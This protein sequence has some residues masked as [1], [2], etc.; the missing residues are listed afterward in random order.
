MRSNS[1]RRVLTSVAAC[2]AV[3]AVISEASAAAPLLG[4]SFRTGG[5]TAGLFPRMY[6]VDLASGAA[7]NP[8]SI[9]VNNTVGIACDPSTGIL[10]GATDQ[11][12]RINNQSGQ[13]GKNLLFTI[14]RATGAAVG[15]GRFDPAGADATQLFEGDLAF[16]PGTNQLYA[17]STRVTSATLMKIDKATG[18]A[19]IVGAIPAPAGVTNFDC[20]AMAFASNGD[21]YVLDS[22]FPPETAGGKTEKAR[23]LRV[24]VTTGALLD[25]IQTPYVLGS[26]AGM[27]IDPASGLIYFADGDTDGS[28]KLYS[29][30]VPNSSFALLGPTGAAGG[31][32]NTF[33]HGLS[34]LTFVVPEPM[35]LTMLA[36]P[37]VMLRRRRR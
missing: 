14:D 31:S 9:N 32:G 37:A 34:G 25:T 12:G 28:D 15:I 19:T 22:A 16:Q 4:V 26:G 24:D 11:F 27:S 13:G 20:S 35:A 8:R 36:V 29:Y 17:L 2:I 21:L 23:L 30:S 18:L 5:Q 7:T 10:Y 3:S 33:D 1:F 6:D